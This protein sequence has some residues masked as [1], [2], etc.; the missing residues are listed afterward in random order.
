MQFKNVYYPSLLH[1]NLR[2]YSSVNKAGQLSYLYKFL[3]C[4]LM[5]L[6][7]AFD[8]YDIYRKK[9]FLI[10]ICKWQI[11]QLTNVLNYLY[12]S[13]NNSI[14]ITQSSIDKVF[15]PVFAET[16]HVFATVFAETTTVF[17]PTFSDIAKIHPMKIMVPSYTF[18]NTSQL[19][20][21]VASCEMIRPLGLKYE[22]DEIV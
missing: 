18:T 5:P 1:E 3:L 19:S 9:M 17:A 10:S 11:G 21:L 6:Q 20:D 14:Y 8:S 22:I 4:V 2:D 12:D 7:N 15:V 13:I 16:T